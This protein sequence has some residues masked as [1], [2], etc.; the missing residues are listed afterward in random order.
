MT[1]GS[2]ADVLELA[3]KGEA[4]LFWTHTNITIAIAGIV[5][6]M[7]YLHSENFI[8]RDLKPSNIFVDEHGHIRIGDFGT[9]RMEDCG[10]KTTSMLGTIPYVAPETLDEAPPTK[11][12][13]VFAFG[14]TLYEILFGEGVFPKNITP[15]QLARRHDRGVRAEIPS[16]ANRTVKTLIEKCWSTNPDD[17]PT[18]ERIYDILEIDRFPFYRDQDSEEIEKFVSEVRSQEHRLDII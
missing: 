15:V 10:S 3:K 1:N 8:H 16:S 5:L 9:T 2:I 14:L 18:F 12:V 11:K 17:R 4:P 6:G 7:R 13:D